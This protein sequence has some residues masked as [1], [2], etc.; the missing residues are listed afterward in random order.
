MLKLGSNRGDTCGLSM[1][2][3]ADKPHVLDVRGSGNLFDLRDLEQQTCTTADGAV[4]VERSA[5]HLRPVLNQRK[6][7]RPLFIGRR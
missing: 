7:D 6:A 2:Y 1:I 4:N 3:I 5:Q